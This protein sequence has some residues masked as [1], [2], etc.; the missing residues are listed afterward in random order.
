MMLTYVT[1]HSNYIIS[2]SLAQNV[3]NL[4]KKSIIMD[5]PYYVGKEM[6]FEMQMIQQ[7]MI[8][9]FQS[10][11]SIAASMACTIQSDTFGVLP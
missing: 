1:Q 2:F 11:I 10:H 4:F 8:A 9:Y 6:K 7:L 5:L 3:N